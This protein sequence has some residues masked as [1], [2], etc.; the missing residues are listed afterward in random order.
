MDVLY[1]EFDFLVFTIKS[2]G[3]YYLHTYTGG[4]ITI[5][6]GIKT[7]KNNLKMKPSEIDWKSPAQ[8]YLKSWF[9]G[10]GLTIL[11]VVLIIGKILGKL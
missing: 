10:I 2:I 7:I 3:E 9:A 4:I 6:I 1:K 5:I 8:G 11:G